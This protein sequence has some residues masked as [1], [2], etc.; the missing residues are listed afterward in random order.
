M[1]ISFEL[2]CQ[3]QGRKA[4]I[5]RARFRESAE[6]KY[7]REVNRKVIQVQLGRLWKPVEPRELGNIVKQLSKPEFGG[8]QQKMLFDAIFNAV[9]TERN[10]TPIEAG[11][12]LAPVITP[13][14]VRL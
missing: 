9:A 4:E 3:E 8:K 7:L 13:K 1:E 6:D 14:Q 10:K 5:L 11:D 12:S 2:F